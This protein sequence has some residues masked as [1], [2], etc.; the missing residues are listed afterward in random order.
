[1]L[2]TVAALILGLI[3]LVWS[4]DRFVI[5]ASAT[6]AILGVSPLVVGILVVGIGTSAPEMLVSGIAAFDG[7][8]GLAVGNALGSNITNIALILGITA[9]YIPLRV[10]SK[11]VTREIPLLMLVMII[12]YVLLRDGVLD[13]IDGAVLLTGFGLVILRQLWEAKHSRGDAIE[14]EFEAE[15]PRD[16]TLPVALGWLLLGLILLMGSARILVWSAVELATAFGVSDLVI[17]LTVVAIGTSLPELAAS[18]AAARK[19]EHD[20]AIG[21]VVGSNLFN[22][23]GVMALPGVIAP[24]PVDAAVISRDYPLM[25]GLTALF[26]LVAFGPRKERRIRRAEGGMLVVIYF[27]YLGYLLVDSGAI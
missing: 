21:N 13:F 15:I 11:L 27:A 12:G 1:M 3:L 20:I 8:P 26:Y 25:L 24:G 7:Q 17:G 5:G 4:A 16:M 14:A 18:V 19:N 10:Q 9:L 22:L 23:L 2:L 6:A